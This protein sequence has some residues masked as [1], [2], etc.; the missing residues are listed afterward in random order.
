MP[1]GKSFLRSAAKHLADT[2][3]KPDPSQAQ[4]DR[5]EEA[6]LTHLDRGYDGL[7]ESYDAARFEGSAGEFNA[8]RDAA[9]VRKLAAQ[10][11]VKVFCDVPV[12]T[13]RTAQYFQGMGIKVIGCD[14][15]GDMLK[16]AG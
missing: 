12:G 3:M 9:I 2:S 4:D 15:S 6:S 11:G 16:I 10:T 8:R 13:G 5:E 1:P 14:L 7:A